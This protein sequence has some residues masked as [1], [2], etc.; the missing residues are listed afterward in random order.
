MDEAPPDLVREARGASENARAPYS[1]FDVG[2]AVQTT[3]GEV[4]R[5]CNVEVVNYT[6]T[7]HA[8]E[9]AVGTA[10]AAG[11]G[12]GDL[13]AVAVSSDT[14][15]TPCGMCRQTLREFAG[16]SLPILVDDGESAVEY[17]LGELLPAAMGPEELLDGE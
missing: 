16:E 10:A 1:G 4:F 14:G 13:A 12:P 9:V 8:E 11:Y 6:N 5:G 2:A 7:M 3:D 17:E 15:V